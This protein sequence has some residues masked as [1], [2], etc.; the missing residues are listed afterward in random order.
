[1][2]LHYLSNSILAIFKRTGDLSNSSLQ[3]WRVSD[4]MNCRPLQTN[5]VQLSFTSR[6]QD[7]VI[8][9]LDDTV[10]FFQHYLFTWATGTESTISPFSLSQN[11][12]VG[13]NR[14]NAVKQK[15][16]TN[17]LICPKSCKNKYRLLLTCWQHAYST[18]KM[19]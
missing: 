10:L 4:L 13:Q 14:S 8:L 18:Y 16:T 5:V 7:Q 11:V 19:Y 2:Y 1:M 3:L 6:I 9:G 12:V 15:F 17:A